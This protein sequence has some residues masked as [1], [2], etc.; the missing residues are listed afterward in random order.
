MHAVFVYL[1]ECFD[2][3]FYNLVNTIKVTLCRS[4]TLLTLFLGRLRPPK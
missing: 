2:L 3:R 4:V 1:I